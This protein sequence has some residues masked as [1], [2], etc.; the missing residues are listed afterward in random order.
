MRVRLAPHNRTDTVL[1]NLESFRELAQTR[2]ARKPFPHIDD[3]LLGTLRA[4]RHVPITDVGRIHAILVS[5]SSRP[6]HIR[7]ALV[8]R[9]IVVVIITVPRSAP[10]HLAVYNVSDRPGMLRR[11]SVEPAAILTPPAGVLFGRSD[12]TTAAFA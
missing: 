3:L 6:R 1:V 11:F 5:A 2:S 7:S 8:L 10:Q 12:A 9:I 4:W